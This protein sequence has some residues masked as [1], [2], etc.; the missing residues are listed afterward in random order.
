MRGT[1]PSASTPGHR[2]LLHA[3]RGFAWIVSGRLVSQGAQFLASIVLARLLVPSAYGLVAITSSFTGFAALF[4][5]LGLGAALVQSPRMTERDAATAFVINGIS[6]LA[7]TLIVVALR[8]PLAN[9]FGQPRVAA[10]LALASLTFTLSLN[11]VPFAILER[12][13]T[14]ARLRPSTSLRRRSDSQ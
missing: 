3:A 12:R 5:D 10:L 2:L 7:L 8:H 4:S 9:L 1:L 14:S 6:G 11:V 13:C